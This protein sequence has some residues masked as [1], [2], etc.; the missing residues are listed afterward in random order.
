MPSHSATLIEAVRSED[1]WRV[2]ARLHCGC[3]VALKVPADR[4]VDVVGGGQ[5]LVG[6]YRCPK[7]HAP[8]S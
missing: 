2:R 4:V 8:G 1:G 5:I 7:D 3:E 6:K